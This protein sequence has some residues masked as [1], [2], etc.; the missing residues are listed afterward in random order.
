MKRFA[1]VLLV[2]LANAAHAQDAVQA[3]LQ[4]APQLVGFAGSPENFYNLVVGLTEGTPARLAA[5]AA[6]GFSRVTT[7]SAP[8]RLGAADAAAL[9]ERA[10][11]NL[12]LLGIVRPTPEQISAALAGGV[13][14]T[15]TGRTQMRGVLPQAARAQVRSR[16]EPDL[17]T[18]TDD[19][20]AFA[21]LPA[22]I[23]A[24]LSGMPPREALLKVQL[25]Q[26]HLIALGNA[27]ASPDRLRAMVQN[28]LAP[29]AG[30][31]TAAVASVSA[32]TTSFPAMSPLVAPYLPA[33]R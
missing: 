31:Y 29:Q 2:G 7:I 3:V 30:G 27:Y 23:Q 6:G 5:P 28:V 22:E 20:R 18:P 10:R 19:E 25:A 26:Q 33:M 17:R 8:A 12:E 15:P 11:Q 13:L 21:Q 16:L 9:L 1:L 32:G 14:D 4:A 24:L